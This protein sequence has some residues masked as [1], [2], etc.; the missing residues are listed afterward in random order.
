MRSAEA[1]VDL[2]KGTA[3]TAKVGFPQN[4]PLLIAFAAQAAGIF[5]A[6]KSAVGA[7]KSATASVG[8]GGGGAAAPSRPAPPSFNI[9]GAAPESQLAQT[10]GE[11]EDKPLKAYVV[12]SDVTT[13]QDLDRNIIEGAS[14]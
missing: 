10:I 6:I 12:S 1:G 8:G 11:R 13:A 2:A 7:A 5:M 4:I 9:V 14:I 3:A